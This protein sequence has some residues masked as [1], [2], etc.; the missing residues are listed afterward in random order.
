[1]H[2]GV[3]G[4]KWGHRKA[5]DHYGGRIT[6]TGKYQASNGI[7]IGKSKNA[8]VTIARR[9]STTNEVAK[10]R[11]RQKKHIAAKRAITIG[12]EFANRYLESKGKNMRVDNAGQL[13][14]YMM[15]RKY[16]RDT[17]R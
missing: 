11:E 2:Y 3:P 10:E 1:M 16:V 15:D 13:A 14:K 4:M 7:V 17:F 6:K 9:L 5:V 8:G 12:T